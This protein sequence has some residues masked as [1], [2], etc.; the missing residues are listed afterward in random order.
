MLVLLIVV[1]LLLLGGGFSYR[2][3]YYGP[4][5]FGGVVVA[6]LLV[7]LILWIAGLLR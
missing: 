2:T 1:I 5:Q 4:G 3:G 6:V 7:L